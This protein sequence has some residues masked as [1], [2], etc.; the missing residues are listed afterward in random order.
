ME[1]YLLIPIK[2]I[3]QSLKALMIAKEAVPENQYILE[4]IRLWTCLL[5]KYKQ[6]EININER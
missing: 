6:I 1:K 3:E 5:S 4:S 2:D